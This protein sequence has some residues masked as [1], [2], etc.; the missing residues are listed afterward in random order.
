M[1]LDNKPYDIRVLDADEEE[2]LL[3][4]LSGTRAPTK[5][6]NYLIIK[7]MLETGMRTDTLINLEW[8]D[9]NFEEG[10]VYIDHEDPDKRRVIYVDWGFIDKLDE[11][12][13]DQ[14]RKIGNTKW[15]FTKLDG[16]RISGRYLRKMIYTYADNC[17][18][19]YDGRINPSVLRHTFAVKL[20]A[21]DRISYQEVIKALG[22][23]Q[24]NNSTAQ[25]RKVVKHRKALKQYEEG[26]IDEFELD[27]MFY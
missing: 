23:K 15:V 22:L 7:M 19:N 2:A 4:E 20:M 5:V 8:R 16:E 13:L 17:H 14:K 6:R 25:Y 10:S 26:K 18:L 12:S 9:I 24:R 1:Y 27:E 3:E 21:D 11:W